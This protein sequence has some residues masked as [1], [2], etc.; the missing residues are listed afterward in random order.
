MVFNITYFFFTANKVSNT[1]FIKMGVAQS[2]N[3]YFRDRQWQRQKWTFWT[4]ARL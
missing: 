4:W 3:W 1:K 2:S